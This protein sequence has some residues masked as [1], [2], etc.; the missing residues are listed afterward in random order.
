MDF[1]KAIE[2]LKQGKKVARKG[3]NGKGMFLVLQPGSEVNG[4]EMRNPIARNYYDMK[5]VKIAPYIDLKAA[6]DTYVVGWTASQQD[7]LSEDWE[8]VE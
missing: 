3:W 6:D 1:G 2:A 8:L 4:I 5:R 7:M